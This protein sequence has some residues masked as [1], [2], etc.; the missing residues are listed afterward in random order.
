MIDNFI[1]ILNNFTEFQALK[2]FFISMAPI[3]ELRLSIP[4]GILN[5]EI[6]WYIVVILSIIGNIF[7]GCIVLYLLPHI[8]IVI[9]KINIFNKIYDFII[10]RTKNRSKIIEQRKYYGLI[11][12]VS[13]PLPFSGV[14]TGA[15]ASNLLGLSRKK[16]ILAICIGVLISSFFVTLLVIIFEISFGFNK[17]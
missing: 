3:T 15:L 4:Y 7:V 5:T 10:K 9:T 16:S 12:F 8:I 13:I 6:D 1:R 2:I 17:H 11:I 14:W